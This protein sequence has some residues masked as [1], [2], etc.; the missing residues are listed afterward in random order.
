MSQ[1]LGDLRDGRHED[2]IEEQFEPRDLAAGFTCRSDPKRRKERS[3]ACRYW[4][5]VN[6]NMPSGVTRPNGDNGAA[7]MRAI[8][9]RGTS[10]RSGDCNVGWY[11]AV[12]RLRT[13]S[14]A[15]EVVEVVGAED[16]DVG[17]DEHAAAT[18][19][20]ASAS[21]WNQRSAVICSAPQ[22]SSPDP[23]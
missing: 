18:S 8:G 6:V 14:P 7:T 11:R 21:A 16:G 9:R 13:G 22:A 12:A 3:H 15:A 4:I 10:G 20:A 5:R 19:D 17:V 1:R 23:V 2:Q